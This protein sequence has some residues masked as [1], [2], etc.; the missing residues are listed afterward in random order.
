MAANKF[1]NV[2]IFLLRFLIESTVAILEH[3]IPSFSITRFQARCFSWF[4]APK[5]WSNPSSP[6]TT[7]NDETSSKGEPVAPGVQ[8]ELMPKHVAVIMDGNQRWAKERGLPPSAGHEAGVQSLERL[9][10]NCCNWGIKVLTVFAFST[11]NWVRPKMEVDFLMSLFE[12]TINSQS[13]NIKRNGIRLS[14]IGDKSKLPKSLQRLIR[15]AEERTK[16]NS[17]LQL[18]VA[19]NY[20]GKYDVVQACKSVAKKAIHDLIQLEDIDEN[21][22]EQELET[23]C[24][25][26]PHPDLLIRTSGELRISNFL[27]WQL[28]YT[29]LHFAPK[30]WPDFGKDE[31][32]DALTLFQKRQR[33]YGGR[34]WQAHVC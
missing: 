15:Y 10:E 25:E 34:N 1:W 9:L 4:F 16:D 29:E 3:I 19:I 14:V 18:I 24:T 27:L 20:S 28:A 12:R 8:L 6:A 7:A 26:F 33:R 21:L 31:F 11:E 5:L 32:V 22:I 13:E 30:F 2:M 17:K 23:K